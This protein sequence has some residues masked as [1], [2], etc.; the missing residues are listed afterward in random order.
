MLA[1]ACVADQPRTPRLGEV[2]T[3]RPEAQPARAAPADREL[4]VRLAVDAALDPNAAGALD[5]IAIL[6]ACDRDPRRE[7]RLRT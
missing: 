4:A 7:R 3:E 5:P 2:D 6:L 1:G